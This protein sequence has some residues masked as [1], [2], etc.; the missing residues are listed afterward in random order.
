MFECSEPVSHLCGGR[1]SYFCSAAQ[2][3]A[4]SPALHCCG[5]PQGC[6]GKEGRAS[7][8][9]SL[10]LLMQICLQSAPLFVMANGYWEQDLKAPAELGVN[11]ISAA[12][13]GCTQGCVQS[14]CH[15]LHA[16]LA[17]PV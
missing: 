9:L 4:S 15:A 1:D 11:V 2:L 5:A 12:T 17:L 7:T 14:A 6:W 16:D 3:N 13:F 10:V 8:Q